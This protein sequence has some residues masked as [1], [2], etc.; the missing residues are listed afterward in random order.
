VAGPQYRVFLSHSG[1][2]KDFVRELYRRLMRDGV[3]CFF[4]AESIGWGDNWVRTLERAIDECEFIVFVLSPDFC[5]SEW[6]EVERTSSI[7]GDPSG[8]RRKV[9]PLLLRP[10]R[11]LPTFPRLLRQVQA[12][13]VSTNA[14]FKENYPRIC[15]QLGGI[16]REDEHFGEPG[17]APCLRVTSILWPCCGGRG[18]TL[19]LDM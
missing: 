12:I 1:K 9:R 8:L 11:D 4:D 3:S 19:H 5:N 18:V 7:A 15:K 6:V 17:C 2:D 16:P 13:D 10:C 14:L